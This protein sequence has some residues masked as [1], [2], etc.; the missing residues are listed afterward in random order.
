M[1][2]HAIKLALLSL[3]ATSGACFNIDELTLI[4]PGGDAGVEGVSD[5]AAALRPCTTHFQCGADEHCA[6]D[7]FCFYD[8]CEPSRCISESP[9]VESAFTTDGRS[10]FYAQEPQREADG[11]VRVGGLRRLMS[12]GPPLVG[13]EVIAGVG[14]EPLQDLHEQGDFVYWRTE[15]GAYRAPK[16]GSAPA[17]VLYAA[18][19]L[20]RALPDGRLV[21]ATDQ[22]DG[23]CSLYVGSVDGTQTLRI[24][25]LGEP[26]EAC[27]QALVSGGAVYY[28]HRG[29]AGE[30]EL[31][32]AD[33]ST[34]LAGPVGLAGL[35]QLIAIDGPYAYYRDASEPTVIKRF[36]LDHATLPA[37]VVLRLIW[38]TVPEH[39][40][41]AIDRGWL[42]MVVSLGPE[43]LVRVRH[44]QV[45]LEPLGDTVLGSTLSLEHTRGY[46]FDLSQLSI[47][48]RG[49]S[50]LAQWRPDVLA[51]LPKRTL[52]FSFALFG[53]Y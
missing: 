23:L 47:E 36:N 6:P 1:N 12:E 28:L 7:G 51:T 42:N 13:P 8:K 2:T 18:D 22:I 27:A 11:T 50:L 49:G 21:V 52:H 53:A 25:S 44:I 17:Q 38:P 31:Y 37:E 4:T 16:D 43:P 33:L 32:R 10:V 15:G 9:Y 26:P 30:L 5:G 3:C 35:E 46:A 24:V 14:A 41:F 20:V 40:V 39:M 19:L 29:H 48:S 45:S 34:S